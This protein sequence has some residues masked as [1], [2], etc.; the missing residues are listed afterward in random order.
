MGGVIVSVANFL[1]ATTRDSTDYWETHCS[2]PNTVIST[3]R[4]LFLGDEAP[5][6]CTGYTQIDWGIFGYF[7]LGSV[8]LTA[9]LIGF[10]WIE[11]LRKLLGP[12]SDDAVRGY[13]RAGSSGVEMLNSEHA[14]G[15]D[16]SSA[17]PTSQ[18]Y[19]L[20]G[21]ERDEDDDEDAVA[22]DSPTLAADEE[23]SDESGILVELKLIK[24]PVSCVFIT[25]VFTLA[26]FPGWTSQLKSSRQCQIHLRLANDLYTP[27]SFV[28]F[29]IGDLVGR[30]LAD[31]WLAQKVVSNR[32]VTGSL[33]RIVFFPLLFVCTSVN[34]NG[35][36]GF[37]IN[38]DLFSLLVQFAF[39]VTN[40][41]ML[42]SA[43]ATAP[44][45]LPR[46]NEA[47]NERMSEIMSFVVAFGLL[48]GGLCSFPVAR[49]TE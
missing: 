23:V 1:A 4:V 30:L 37:Q 35:P 17:R 26:L 36:L 6:N 46:G 7:F 24:G 34:A 14:L 22:T 2:Q 25:F 45:L 28:L 32:L 5:Q 43:F 40:G 9:C 13:Q 20:E 29:N 39:S 3:S 42:T 12:E 18:S 48:V 8:V 11:P 16:S 38:N 31:S 49:L 44:T 19:L 15:A 10:T 47:M 27:F 21:S 41:M 33:A